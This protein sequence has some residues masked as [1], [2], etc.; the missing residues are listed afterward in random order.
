MKKKRLLQYAALTA[1]T[2]CSLSV[3]G[4]GS[5]WSDGKQVWAQ[6]SEEIQASQVCNRGNAA[7]V[8]IKNGKGHG[9]G[10]VVRRDGLIIT[11]AHV[12]DGGPRVVTVVF[13]NGKQ[14]PADVIGFARGGV[15]LAALKIHNQKNLPTLALAKTNYAKRGYRVFAI[16]TPLNP[17]FN[18][19]CTQGNISR[20]H[21]DGM[22]QHN[23]DTNKGNS[24]G[25]LLNS[26]GEVIGV[27][28]LVAATPVFDPTGK[29]R[30]GSIAGGNGIN[31]ALPI[32]KVNSFIAD[33]DNNRSSKVSTL[34]KKETPSI[35]SISLNG[36]IINGSLTTSDRIYKTN[37]RF[38][39]LYRFQGQV[40]QQIIIE[41]KSQKINPV[42]TLY[43]LTP[44]GKLKEIAAND[45]RGAGDFNAEIITTLPNNGFYLITAQAFERGETGNYRLRVT[46]NP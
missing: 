8:T 7:V 20:I 35:S 18:N 34:P 45:D 19:T 15:D 11:N 24:G 41:M 26:Q 40:G 4:L 17:I 38:I 33:V 43:Q 3:T 6:T 30:I 9:S 36:Q 13:E 10:F 21:K 27:S 31:L 28:T 14:F 12:V 42:L 37:G 5:L 29:T 32:T 46:A 44:E 23:A 16:G 22:I 1:F 2:L 25:P 39:D